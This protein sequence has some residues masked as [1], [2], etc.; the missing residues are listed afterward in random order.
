MTGREKGAATAPCPEC[1]RDRP[2]EQQADG[3]FAA[4]AHTTC[5]PAAKKTEVREAAAELTTNR[6]RGVEPQEG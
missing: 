2:L 1:G 6:E 3:S 5:F 4:S